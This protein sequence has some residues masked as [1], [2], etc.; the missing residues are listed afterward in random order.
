MDYRKGAETLFE[1]MQRTLKLDMFKNLNDISQG[2]MAVLGYLSF[3]HDGAT[4]GEL[5]A[6]FEVGTSRTAA[7]LNTLEKKEFARRAHDKLDK[8]RVL[9]FISNKGKAEVC[10][11]RAAAID[12]MMDFLEKLGDED[13]AEAIRIVKKAAIHK[14]TNS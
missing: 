4:A 9:V 8:R 2:E 12:C 14:N 3:Q 5:S 7:I 10:R 1:Y 13:A 11:K 6:A